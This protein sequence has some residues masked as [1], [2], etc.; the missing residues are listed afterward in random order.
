MMSAGSVSRRIELEMVLEREDEHYVDRT[1]MGRRQLVLCMN[2]N[3]I[4]T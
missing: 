2:S 4:Y 1:M 3:N